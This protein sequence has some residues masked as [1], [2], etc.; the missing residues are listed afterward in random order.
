MPS[1][2]KE[3]AH[4]AAILAEIG[5]GTKILCD[6]GARLKYSNSENL[7]NTY[8]FTGV[9]VDA[10]EAACRELA[11][12]FGNR[13]TVFHQAVTPHRVN[14][15]VPADTWFLSIDID[16]TDFW[17]WANLVHRPAIVVVE[18]NPMPWVFAAKMEADCKDGGGYGMSVDA[19][20]LLG[21][22]KGYDYIGRTEA[23]CLFVLKKLGCKYR[24]TDEPPHRGK[25]CGS[26][27]NVF[28]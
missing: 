27:N 7:I 23:N 13:V 5:T 16:S 17:V 12:A 8:G 6:L 15:I 28:A 25:A 10:S 26:A 14:K 9:L 18:T 11:V 1:Q 4:I 19:A 21:E 22:L 2:F 20:R 3:D 24:I